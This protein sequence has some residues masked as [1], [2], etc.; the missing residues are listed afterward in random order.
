MAACASTDVF[1]ACMYVDTAH[2]EQSWLLSC[3]Y[4]CNSAAKA[5][6]WCDDLM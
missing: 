4:G 6:V 5:M 2:V 3:G 1:A